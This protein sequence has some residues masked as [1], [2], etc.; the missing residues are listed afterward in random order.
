MFD[1]RQD[2][3]IRVKL[4]RSGKTIEA[5]GVRMYYECY[6]E[7]EPL[8]LFHGGMSTID[9]FRFQI[10]ALSR[11]YQVIIP[12]RRG[13]GHTP[14]TGGPFSYDQ[15]A[16][17]MAAFMKA[18]GLG[19]SKMLGYSDGANLILYLARRS[20]ELVERFISVGGNFHHKGC[21]EAFQK[22][23][24]E[25]P[26]DSVGEGIDRNYEKY[27]PDG[28]AHYSRV[29]AKVRR[30]WLEEPVFEEKDLSLIS[31]PG[32][33]MAGDRDVILREHTLDFYRALPHARLAI[34]PGSHS[35][36]KELPEACNEIILEYLSKELPDLLDSEPYAESSVND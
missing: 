18:L 15:M 21:I 1:F 3:Y 36:L 24:R 2:L 30:L 31:A 4:G 14:D 13:H 17:D 12:E 5:G 33:V 34:L 11:H 9:S 27:S 22:V 7:G 26:E 23:L 19:K 32:L 35:I 20:P 8:L 16:L 6:G 28:P 10:P 25:L 29:F